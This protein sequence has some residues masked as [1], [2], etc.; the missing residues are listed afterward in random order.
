MLGRTGSR[1]READVLLALAEVTRD[2]GDLEDARGYLTEAADLRH[3]LGG[4]ALDRAQ[5][6]L[7]APGPL[8]RTPWIG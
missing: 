2:D 7:N 8:R 3:D 1:N 6:A 5:T 4:A